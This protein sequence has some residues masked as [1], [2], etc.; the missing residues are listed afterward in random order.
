MDKDP[1]HSASFCDETIEVLE[2]EVSVISWQ[3]F[4]SLLS[5]FNFLLLVDTVEKS[6]ILQHKE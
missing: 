4:K 2:E 6:E 3:I 5:I 1:G